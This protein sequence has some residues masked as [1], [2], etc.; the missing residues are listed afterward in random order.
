MKRVT[1][2]DIETTADELSLTIARTERALSDHQRRLNGGAG[3]LDF[4]SCVLVRKVLAGQ[5]ATLGALTE[6]RT[7]LIAGRQ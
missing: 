5:R 2:E 1:V 3:D 4:P 6:L 7:S